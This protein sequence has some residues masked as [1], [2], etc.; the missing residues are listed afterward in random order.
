[1]FI[2]SDKS[3]CCNRTFAICIA[4]NK[5]DLTEWHIIFSYVD[6]AFPR[7]YCLKFSFRSVNISKYYVR[8]LKGFFSETRCTLL[9]ARCWWAGTVLGRDWCGSVRLWFCQSADIFILAGT[10]LQLIRVT[11]GKNVPHGPSMVSLH[12]WPWK[13]KDQGQSL[14]SLSTFWSKSKSRSKIKV[15]EYSDAEIPKSLS[16]LSFFLTLLQTVDLFQ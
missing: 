2:F 15:N 4:A 6:S 3:R 8:K 1:M 10:L 9:P 11:S 16:D 12:F 14:G 13:V 5:E 7:L